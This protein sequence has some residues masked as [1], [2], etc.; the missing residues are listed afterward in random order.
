[1]FRSEDLLD[2]KCLSE[3]KGVAANFR[4]VELKAL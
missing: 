3:I 1:V 2:D 4:E